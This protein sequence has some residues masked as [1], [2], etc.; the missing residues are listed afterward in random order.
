MTHTP[1]ERLTALTLA[2]PKISKPAGNLLGYKI[3]RGLVYVSGQLPLEDGVAKYFGR[4]GDTVSQETAYE[5]AKLAALNVISQL[6]MA[7]NQDLSLIDELIKVCGFVSCTADFTN[8]SAV[9][10]GASDLFVEVFGERGT[11]SRFA[12]GVAALPRGV[13]VE[14]EVIA[15]LRD[16][17]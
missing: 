4:V 1:E 12:I 7:T 17:Q 2:L 16:V 9:I 5:A 10:N 3:D 13:P 6:S 14:I 8:I 15:R 11:H